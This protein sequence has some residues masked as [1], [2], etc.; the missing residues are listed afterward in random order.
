MSILGSSKKLQFHAK[1]RNNKSRD[2][3]KPK[4]VFGLDPDNHKTSP[5]VATGARLNLITL[6]HNWFE[7]EATPD[8][9][10]NRSV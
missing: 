8:C 2:G 5:A 4:P 6:H 9:T 3:S 10:F 1:Q 7:L